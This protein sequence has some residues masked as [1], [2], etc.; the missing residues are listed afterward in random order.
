M[1]KFHLRLDIL[2]ARG[3]GVRN[4]LGFAG[5]PGD[6]GYRVALHM[7]ATLVVHNRVRHEHA[8]GPSGLYAARP[9]GTSR[10]HPAV[11]AVVRRCVA[12][13]QRAA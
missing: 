5:L 2:A 1:A 10:R 12:E 11:A 13:R 4:M 8:G 3:R 6:R 9:K 7:D